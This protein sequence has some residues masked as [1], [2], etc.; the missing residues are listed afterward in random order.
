MSK[1][2]LDLESSSL[3]GILANL[4]FGTESG[5][6]FPGE[7]GGRMNPFQQWRS[8]EQATISYGY[9]LAVTSLQLARAYAAIADDG[10]VRPVTFI[11]GGNDNIR[12]TETRVMSAQT[13]EQIR[14]MMEQVTATGG[15]ATRA[16]VAEYR[17][18][19][20]T[21]TVRKMGKN[22]YAEENYRALFAGIAP[23]SDPRLV[24]VTVIDQPDSG[25]YY[26]GVVAAPLFSKVMSGALRLLDQGAHFLPEQ[27]VDL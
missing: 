20:K 13:A 3:W 8:V 1:I 4:G 7:I 6:L 15:T 12:G 26:G 5:S 16:Q 10:L 17:I 14:T 24:M 25:D 22:G 27:V 2:A 21:G 19:G 23:A 9:G 18:A 11:K